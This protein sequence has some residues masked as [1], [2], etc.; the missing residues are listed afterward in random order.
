MS[1]FSD[2][3]PDLAVLGGAVDQVDGV[4]Q[5]GLHDLEASKACRVGRHLLVGVLPRAPGPRVLVEELDRLRATLVAAL[6]GVGR[7]P[8]GGH[9]GAD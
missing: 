8:R 1:E 9:V 5:R 6:H 4:D 3:A 2:L 7:P